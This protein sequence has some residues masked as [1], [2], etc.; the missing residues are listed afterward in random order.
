MHQSAAF[1]KS[2]NGFLSI[3]LTLLTNEPTFDCFFFTGVGLGFAVGLGDGDGDGDGDGVGVAVGVALTF[4]DMF[5][6]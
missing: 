6:G 1:H 2:Q 4:V 5:A 3:R